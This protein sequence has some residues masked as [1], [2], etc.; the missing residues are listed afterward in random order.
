MGCLHRRLHQSNRAGKRQHERIFLSRPSSARP[1]SSQRSL[2]IR[3]QRLRE[4]S[5][6]LQREHPGCFKSRSTSQEAE[7]GVA[8]ERAGTATERAAAGAGGGA[9][10]EEERGFAEFE[11]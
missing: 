8:G 11:V 5:R 3:P 9:D 2:H 10:A 1:K 4:M 7:V 6:D